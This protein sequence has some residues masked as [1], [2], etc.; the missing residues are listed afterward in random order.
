MKCSPQPGEAIMAHRFVEYQPFKGAIPG[1]ING[2]LIAMH[3]GTSI[4]FALDKLQ[5]RGKFF[6]AQ[7]RRLHRN[8]DWRTF[9]RK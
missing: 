5:E 8:G 4:P 7:V 1:R 3:A 2:S 9:S 6:I